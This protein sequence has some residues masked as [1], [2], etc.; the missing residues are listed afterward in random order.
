MKKPFFQAIPVTM[1][2]VIKTTPTDEQLLEAWK[3]VSDH[4]V[5][6]AFPIQVAGLDLSKSSYKTGAVSRDRIRKL[7]GLV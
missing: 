6:N 1:S 5:M 2:S 4:D 7:R 3:D